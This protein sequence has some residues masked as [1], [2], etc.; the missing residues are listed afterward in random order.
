[1]PFA[2][3]CFGAPPFGASPFAC[4][5]FLVS[6]FVSAIDFDSGALREAHLL[7]VIALADELEADA[8]WLAVLRIGER[9]IGHMDRPLLGDD[10]A[11]LLR[12]LALVALDHV[13]A[14]HDRTA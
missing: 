7:A 2:A 3:A 4:F 5:G 14:A 6:V 12:R 11:F 8:G 9:Q 1:S 10:P 13:D